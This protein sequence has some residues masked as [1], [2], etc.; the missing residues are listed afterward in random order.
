MA[1]FGW[2]TVLLIALGFIVGVPVVVEFARTGLVDRL[3][4]ALLAVGLV[5]S[6][7]LSLVSGLIL[8]TVVKGSRK[9]YE[10]QCE[11]HIKP[12]IG[13]IKLTD[14]TPKRIQTF[15][16]DLSSNGN[17]K[18]IKDENGDPIE[19]P[20][21]L[22]PITIKNIAAVLNSCLNSAVELGYLKSNPAHYAKPP[23]APPK[24]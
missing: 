20:L 14:L 11:T 10:L 15:Y 3:P 2:V 17:A 22:S 12:S 6:G 18:Q 13:A 8:D 4:S 16:N 1:L 24:D 21:P 23:K 9:Q 5:I 19:S 7:L